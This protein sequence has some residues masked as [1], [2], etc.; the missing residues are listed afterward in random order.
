MMSSQ[1]VPFEEVRRRAESLLSYSG[2][3]QALKADVQFMANVPLSL[4]DKFHHITAQ[5][6]VTENITGHRRQEVRH[7]LTFN[8]IPCFTLC[9]S[10]P[11]S[12]SYAFFL[13]VCPP[14]PL[15]PQVLESLGRL[16]KA[17]SILEKYGCNLT[18]PS[19]PRYWRSVKHNNPVFRTTV[20]E[21][22]V[23][24]QTGLSK[25]CQELQALFLQ[26]ND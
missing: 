23:K 16:C 20:D 2:S 5:T 11:S 6:M 12:H 21:I 25:P 26:Y 1:P 14:A 13:P 17:L 4:S 15:P 7:V 9:A 8:C 18:S 22:K 10:L 3:A 19:R 24:R